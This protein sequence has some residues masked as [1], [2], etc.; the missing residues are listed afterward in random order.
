MQ[1]AR[2][3]VFVG[4]PKDLTDISIATTMAIKSVPKGYRLLFID[5]ISTL[6]LYNDA[7]TVAKFTHFLINKM[8]ELK[9]TGVIISLEKE[10]DE[11]MISQLSQF[12]DKIV[13][14]KK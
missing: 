2:N 9:C 5:S 14:V 11:K 8:R 10:T 6:G 12:C 3:A 7:G 4:S 1:K 13:K